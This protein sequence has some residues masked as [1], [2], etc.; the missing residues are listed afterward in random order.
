RPGEGLLLLLG[1]LD[2]RDDHRQL[3]PLAGVL[4]LG[5]AECLQ[6]LQVLWPDPVRAV[7]EGRGVDSGVR[8]R[9][10][11]LVVLQVA[12][13]PAQSLVETDSHGQSS[14]LL[15]ILTS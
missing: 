4:V 8:E 9:T 14:R 2:H 12:Q 15:Y 7:R 11:L 1:G 13:G 6:V 5:V 10:G 3:E